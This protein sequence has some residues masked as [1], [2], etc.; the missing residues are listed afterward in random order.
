M[1]R[2]AL[3][4]IICNGLHMRLQV[5]ALLSLTLAPVVCA[6]TKVTATVVDDVFANGNSQMQD[7]AN[8]SM[9]LFNG[10]STSIR[11]DQVGAIT[12]DVTPVAGSSEAWWAYFTNAGSPTAGSQRISRA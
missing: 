4:D 3:W 2:W 11:T 10:R 8:N 6:Q 9:W 12:Y 7:L 5:L 1:D